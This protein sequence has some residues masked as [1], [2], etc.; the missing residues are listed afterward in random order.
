MTLQ[1][2]D[3]AL[4]S[5]DFEQFACMLSGL[6]PGFSGGAIYGLG[7]NKLLV[8]DE[9]TESAEDE[10][11]LFLE[12]QNGCFASGGVSKLQP[13]TIP[14]NMLLYCYTL[15]NHIEE[16]VGTLI[17]LIKPPKGG[18]AAF[19]EKQM[20]EAIPAMVPSFQSYISAQPS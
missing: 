1:L 6:I 3:N 9:F 4:K 13:K 2:P 7:N 16:P 11:R 15:S 12:E 19:L 8:S 10:A 14:N 20:A 18:D 5:L 17:L